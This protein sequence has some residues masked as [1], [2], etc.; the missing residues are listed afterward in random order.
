MSAC[1]AGLWNVVPGRRC[2]V[3]HS[4]PTDPCGMTDDDTPMVDRPPS[5]LDDLTMG[6]AVD[7]AGDLV[8]VQ[9]KVT[10]GHSLISQL[11][12]SL[13]DIAHR[14]LDRAAEKRAGDP[15]AEMA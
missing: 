10:V 6:P 13:M 12:G 1:T 2:P 4:K 9:I 7:E 15:D 8:G 3:C 11:P 14:V 5:W